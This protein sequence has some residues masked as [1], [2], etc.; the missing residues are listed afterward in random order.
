MEFKK[1]DSTFWKARVLRELQMKALRSR[2]P[3][4]QHVNRTESAVQVVWDLENST[5]FEQDQKCQIRL[6]MASYLTLKGEIQLRVESERSLLRN[7]EIAIEKLLELIE[8]SFEVPKKRFKTRPTRSSI[9]RRIKGKGHRSQIKKM[10]R[11][12]AE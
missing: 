5:A 3:G 6:K 7:K 12:Q 2:G 11:K 4:G 9:E 8:R 10:R 1:P